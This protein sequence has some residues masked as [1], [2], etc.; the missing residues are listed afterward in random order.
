MSNARFMVNFQDVSDVFCAR[1]LKMGVFFRLLW[2]IMRFNDILM[3]MMMVYGCL[4]EIFDNVR[5][6]NVVK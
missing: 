3:E 6:K 1:T 2:M 4:K 5:F